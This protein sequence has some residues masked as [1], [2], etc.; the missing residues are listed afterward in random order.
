MATSAPSI[1]AAYPDLVRGAACRWPDPEALVFSDDR[2]TYDELLDRAER[3]AAE[4]IQLGVRHGDHVG[5]LMPNAPATIELFVATGMVGGDARADQ[6][7]L[8]T[9]EL[10]HVITRPR[11][12]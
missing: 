5:V 4:L 9:R 12:R 10:T 8:Q 3:R 11:R 2:I 1:P 6:H 7:A